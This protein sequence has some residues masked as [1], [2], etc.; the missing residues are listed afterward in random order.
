MANKEKLLALFYSYLNLE[1]TKTSFIRARLSI[2]FYS[3][4]NLESTKTNKRKVITTTRFYSYL[5]LESTKTQILIYHV[6][7]SFI[8]T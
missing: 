6:V 2:A 7:Y 5:N 8:V 4:L 3:Y 1:S